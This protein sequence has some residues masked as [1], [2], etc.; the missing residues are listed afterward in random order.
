ME[1]FVISVTCPLCGRIHTY[2]VHQ[3][4]V[5]VRNSALGQRR[6]EA[7][8]RRIEN[9]RFS[10]GNFGNPLTVTV[11]AYCPETWKVIKVRLNRKAVIDKGFNPEII[12]LAPNTSITTEPGGGL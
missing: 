2:S 8:E 4:T 7:Y 5:A 9:S 3:K 12:S 1:N 11:S 6:S 10:A